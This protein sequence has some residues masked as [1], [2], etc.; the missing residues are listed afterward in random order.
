MGKL[1]IFILYMLNVAALIAQDKGKIIVEIS[2]FRNNCGIA[3]VAIFN[4]ANG[5]PDCPDKALII[6][7]LKIF[8]KT[9]SVEYTDLLY[10]NFAIG[11]I[12]DENMNDIMDTNWIGIPKEG[13]AVSNN[14]KGNF[15]PPS[16]DDAKIEL[17]KQIQTIQIKMLY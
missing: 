17:Q 11:V 12:H 6:K 16:Y 1:I 9:V 13:Y 8:N 2:G 10:G 4:S 14:A 3:K 5:F 15:G 7:R